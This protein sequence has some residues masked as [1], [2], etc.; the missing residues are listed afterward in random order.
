MGEEW[1]DRENYE[2]NIDDDSEAIEMMFKQKAR[3]DPCGEGGIE[4]KKDYLL[5]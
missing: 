2:E 1:D 5:D 3:T 4:F